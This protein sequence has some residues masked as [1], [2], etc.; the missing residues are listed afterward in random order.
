MKQVSNVIKSFVLSSSRHHSIPQR[1]AFSKY[2]FVLLLAGIALFISSCQ[3]D[4][5]LNSSQKQDHKN[6]CVPF[7]ANFTTIDELTQPAT[8]DNPI[9]KDRITGTGEGTH[10]GK[11]TI[12]VFAEGDITLPFPALVTSTG[13]FTAANG[14]KIFFAGSGN[15][16]EPDANGNLHLT[17]NSTITGGTGRFTGATGRIT[18]YVVQSINTPAGTVRFEGTICY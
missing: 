15:V 2:L 6:K 12:E 5:L 9:Q 10:I 13:T 1:K 7:K 8:D 11:A 3:K 18:G 16:N 14:D 17:A 4:E